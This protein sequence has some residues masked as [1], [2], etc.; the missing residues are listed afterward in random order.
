MIFK[1]KAYSPLGM[2][3]SWATM[4][5]SEAGPGIVPVGER[6][7]RTTEAGRRHRSCCTRQLPRHGR[8]CGPFPSWWPSCMPPPSCEGFRPSFPS[9]ALPCLPPS[10]V[11]DPGEIVDP[12]S[13]FFVRQLGHLTSSPIFV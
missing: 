1:V 3:P 6:P 8:A 2:P 5:I 11:N 7:H 12:S 9:S 13:R 10:G 4:S